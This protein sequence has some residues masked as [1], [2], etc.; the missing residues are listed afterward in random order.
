MAMITA[1]VDDWL[2]QAIREF[3]AEHGIGP[4]AGYRHVAEEWWTS[5]CFPLLEFRDGVSGRRAGVRSGPDV[6]EIIM[7]ARDYEDDL[8]GLEEHFGGLVS[9]EALKQALAYAKQFPET[10]EEWV[11]GNER[12]ERLL[13]RQG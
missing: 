12:I 10:V 8:C 13:T 5:Q 2:G 4:S 7:V 1:R 9:G 3:W 11:A 6:W